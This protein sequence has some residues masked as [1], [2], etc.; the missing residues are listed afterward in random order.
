VTPDP[1]ATSELRRRV[2][3]AWR[4]SPA[5]F[6][7]DANVEDDLALVGYRDRLIVELAQNAADAA[8]R[9]QVPG[10]VVFELTEGVLTATNNGAPLDAAGVESIAVARASAKRGG[11]G[12]VGRFGVGF[13]AVLAVSDE[14]S[15][16]SPT[17]GVRWSRAAATAAAGEIP[18]L[19]EEIAVRGDRVPVLR[20][21]FAAAAEPTAA[22]LTTVRL[23]LRDA[24][25]VEAVR[26]QLSSIDPTLLIS[27]EALTE[28][29]VRLPGG[30]RT[31]TAT[32]QPAGAYHAVA[33]TDGGITSRWLRVDGRGRLPTELV[34]AGPTEDR[35]ADAWQ[36]SWALP[37][38]PDGRLVVLPES[39]SGV[40]RAPTATDDPMSLPAVLVA[41]Y[42]LD[43]TRRRITAGA[44]CDEVS[45]RAAEVLADALADLPPD[46][47]LLGLVPTGFPD[48]EV[49]GGLRAALLDRLR[50]TAWLPVAAEPDARQRPRDAVVVADPLVEVLREVAPSV[51]PA[52][53][54]RPELAA[55]GVRRPSVAELVDALAGVTLDPTGWGELYTAFDEAVPPGPERDALGALPV[56]LTDGTVVTGPRG[57]VLPSAATPLVDL[58]A[59][60]IRMVHPDAVRELL[61]TLG[62]GDG[63][64]RG[65]L[66]QPQVRAAVAASYDEEDPTAIAEAVLSLVAAADAG[67]D[68]LPWLADLALADSDGGWRPA[69]ELLL[70]SGLM[71][72]IVGADTAFGRLDEEWAARWGVTTVVAAGVIDRPTLLRDTD[73]LGPTHDLDDEAR[74]WSMLPPDAAVEDFVAVRDLEQVRR[75]AL[76][77]LVPLLATPPWRSA[78]VEPALVTRPDGTRLRA[79]TY[80]AWWLSSRPVLAGQP[81]R[82]LRLAA[83]D[84]VLDGIY[85][86][87]PA[88]A[89]DAVLRAIG[90][91]DSLADADPDD[92]LARLSQDQRTID[93]RQLRAINDWLTT[94]PIVP[95][96]RVR[97]VRDG[98][99]VVVAADEAVV[100]D[101]PDLF[102]LLGKLA[103]VPA[104]RSRAAALAQRLDLPL[105]SRLSDYPV[106]SR[107]E[108][109]D[110]AV[111]HEVLRVAD[112]D[113]VER[114]VAWRLADDVLHV[115]ARHLAVGLGRGRAWRDGAWS[116]RHRRTEALAEFTVGAMRDNEDDLDDPDEY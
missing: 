82:H 109:V 90:V 77:D 13:A 79:D 3:A 44:L 95:P 5:R 74:W 19:R 116:W 107:G 27:L 35:T 69:G 33:L 63:T 10:R 40:V 75:S 6:R 97:A 41:S 81:P 68:E 49:D 9:A 58:A 26:A 29:V 31:V 54:S 89:D 15:I 48:G 34:A 70:P 87:A 83:G 18:E 100:V 99:T 12:F 84:P 21:P 1:F 17:G 105:A 20:L 38:D 88:V 7:A 110:D 73:A 14:P 52:G 101:A 56:P 43:A 50:H 108:V 46:P 22:G 57:L 45:A 113:G 86:V 65:L 61:R 23:P 64:P 67:I 78:I 16:A 92:V 106:V 104:S 55:L 94:L 37:V 47:S 85:D 96:D 30:E 60:G 32:R 72:G 71:A 8:A 114:E 98:A 2:L 39:V 59:I 66:E 111:V 102:P 112:V 51:L 36:V 93:R 11:E 115:D 25:A 91:L 80:T 76:P 53:W 42:P 62:A 103:V 24:D 4:E 28:L